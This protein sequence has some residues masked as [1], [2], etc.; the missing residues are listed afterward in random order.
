MAR[1][2]PGIANIP[3]GYRSRYEPGQF[4]GP[5]VTGG[6]QGNYGNAANM[7]DIGALYDSEMQ[8]FNPGSIINN[9]LAEQGATQAQKIATDYGLMRA[10]D[11]RDA[12]MEAA[13]ITEKY[14]NEALNKSKGM[15]IAGAGAGTFLKLAPTLLAGGLSDKSTKNTIE[16]IE[17]ATAKLRALH[18][19]SFYY[20]E[21]WSSS[22]ERQHHGFIAQEYKEVLPDATYYDESTKK[23][24]IDTMDVIGILV[25]GFQELDTRITRIEAKN[26]LLA[27]VK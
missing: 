27:G 25:R 3:L 11:T 10:I 14:A 7:V 5:V 2:I 21:E 6:R 8:G 13:D 17:N 12:R 15:G 23:L 18:P 24:C 1:S 20:N 22:P 9:H 26:A 4:G 19:V 16:S